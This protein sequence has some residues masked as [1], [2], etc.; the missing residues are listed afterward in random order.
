M[1]LLCHS[2]SLNGKSLR[3]LTYSLP[4]HPSST[5]WKHQKTLQFF[6]VFRGLRKGSLG[7]NGLM[8]EVEL[9]LS[10]RPL[11]VETLNYTNSPTRISLNDLLTLKSNVVM[12]PPGEFSQPDLYSK[13]RWWRI[14]YI[15]EKFWNSWRKE[16]LQSL[17][18]R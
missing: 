16:F 5:P 17:Q 15:A 13:K 6:D 14:Q 9:I 1:C 3:T 7:T 2:L 11:T 10:S 8:T 4:I 12:L 18:P